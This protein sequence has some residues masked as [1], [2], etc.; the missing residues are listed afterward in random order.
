M[1]YV[2]GHKELKRGLGAA[3][4]RHVAGAN[5]GLK[6]AGAYLLGETLPITPVEFGFLR[7][8]G[9]VR[10]LDKVGGRGKGELVTVIIGFTAGYAIYVHENLEAYHRPPTQ[11]K[12]LEKTA[13]DKGPEA[14]KLILESIRGGRK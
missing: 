12:F 7:G 6:R 14:R 2:N 1:A 3:L 4:G 10:A 11:A 9:F 8:S 13:R 5:R